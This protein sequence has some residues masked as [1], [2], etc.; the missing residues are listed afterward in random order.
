MT[1]QVVRILIVLH[2]IV[3]ITIT[4]QFKGKKILGRSN[5]IC[6]DII[7]I[8]VHIVYAAFPCLN[9][10]FSSQAQARVLCQFITSTHVCIYVNVCQH[11]VEP[12]EE[13]QPE[14]GATPFRE[15]SCCETH[16]SLEETRRS[17]GLPWLLHAGQPSYVPFSSR[18]SR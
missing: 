10:L 16:K 13:L 3:R 9:Y 2:C 4:K 15:V 18:P 14:G 11:G 17:S 1:I 6:I 7:I 8:H 12:G 5:L